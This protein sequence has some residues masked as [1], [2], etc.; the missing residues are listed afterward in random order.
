VMNPHQQQQRQQVRHGATV[1]DRHGHRL[2]LAVISSLRCAQGQYVQQ[3]G[4]VQGAPGGMQQHMP[5]HPG[6]QQ[7]PQQ[8]RVS[9][10]GR[11][12]HV[13]SGDRM[14]LLCPPACG[15]LMFTTYTLT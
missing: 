4:Y 2:C 7:A 14:R 12:H 3:P 9:W 1:D 10:G 13:L 15:S 11:R 5:Q 6:Q 8:M